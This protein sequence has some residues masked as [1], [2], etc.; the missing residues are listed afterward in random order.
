MELNGVTKTCTMNRQRTVEF[1][2]LWLVARNLLWSV[3]GLSI[4]IV[5]GVKFCGRQRLNEACPVDLVRHQLVH[6]EERG[7]SYADLAARVQELHELRSQLRAD[8]ALLQSRA[9]RPKQQ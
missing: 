3:V 7:Q 4:I 8:L 9:A 2:E 6:T 5:A 1:E